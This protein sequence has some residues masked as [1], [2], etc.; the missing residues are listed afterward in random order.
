[1]VYIYSSPGGCGDF[2]GG[3]GELNDVHERE[4]NY[5]KRV[6]KYI[7]VLLTCTRKLCVA[8]RLAE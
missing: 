3:C 7:R 5:T 6:N 2:L 1:M 4:F 8:M